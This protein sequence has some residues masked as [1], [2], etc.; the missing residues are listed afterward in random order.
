MCLSMSIPSRAFNLHLSISSDFKQ[1]L[2]VFKDF[3]TIWNQQNTLIIISIL[4]PI[5]TWH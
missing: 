2:I 5:N 4:S 1:P 3:S